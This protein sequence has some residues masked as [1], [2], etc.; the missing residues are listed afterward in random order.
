ME[1]VTCAA[2]INIESGVEGRAGFSFMIC[3]YDTQL[4]VTLSEAVQ[5]V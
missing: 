3:E 2:I 1:A 4:L 5:I